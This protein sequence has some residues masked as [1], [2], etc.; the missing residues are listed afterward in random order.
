MLFA[1]ENNHEIVDT[2][3]FQNMSFS[4]CIVNNMYM[5][6]CVTEDVPT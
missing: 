2:G 1:I 3:Y 4:T 5:Y 6:T